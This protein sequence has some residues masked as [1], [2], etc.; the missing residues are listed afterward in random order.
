MLAG[1]L[2]ILGVAGLAATAVAPGLAILAGAVA[3]LGV[4]C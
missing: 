2:T 4:G 3:L 1:A